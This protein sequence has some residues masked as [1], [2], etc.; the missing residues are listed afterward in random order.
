VTPGLAA[1]HR[2]GDSVAVIAAVD[3][4]HPLAQGGER[5]VGLVLT[6]DENEP[7]MIV[8]ERGAEDRVV[9]RVAVPAA[10]YLVSLE[11]LN[12]ETGAARVRFGHGLAGREPGEPYVSDLLLFEAAAATGEG[13]DAV[14]P[15]MLGTT[16]IDRGR[17]GSQLGVFRETYGLESQWVA[18][19]SISVTPKEGL[20]GRVA[21]ILRLRNSNRVRTS[22]QEVI[23]GTG[24]D[25]VERTLRVDLSPLSTGGHTLEIQIQTEDGAL[26][27]ASRDIEIVR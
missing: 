22:W 20:L 13:L 27:T 8:R 24:V 16:R 18:Q 14:A 23:D 1:L 17:H 10:R 26:V 5:D 4:G 25:H 21:S 12:P 15:H 2:R 7:P 6:R 19:V 9:F 11:G 3:L